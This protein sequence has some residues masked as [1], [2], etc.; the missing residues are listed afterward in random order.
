MMNDKKTLC[1]PTSQN[2]VTIEEH[3]KKS[4]VFISNGS[5]IK[6]DYIL[7]DKASKSK[8]LKAAK[9]IPIA[10]EE[11]STS[12]N[13]IFSAGAWYHTVLPSI[14]Y[15]EDVHQDARE[16]LI[17][18]DYTIKVGGVKLGKESNGKHVNT[19][20]VFFANREKIVCHL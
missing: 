4:E 20:I 12:K 2:I 18:D 19:Q 15:F 7:S 10:V 6:F 5:V 11:N 17:G 13:L 8:L 9:R 1:A 3:I 14:K 16:C